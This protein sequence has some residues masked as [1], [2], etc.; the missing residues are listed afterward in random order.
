MTEP[1]ILAI[2]PGF[3]ALGLAVLDIAAKHVLS[4]SLI[5]TEREAKKRMVHAGSDDGRRIDM[6]S[7]EIAGLVALW[8]PAV[9]AYELPAAAKGSRAQHALGLAHGLVRATVRTVAT[10]LNQPTSIVE[11][12]AGD[13]K[14]ALGLKPRGVTK[15]DVERE[16]LWRFSESRPLERWA[17]ETKAKDKREHGFDACAV[18]VAASTTS[19]ALALRGRAA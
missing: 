12:T 8:Q 5:T 3:A 15:L 18:G 14:S 4:V 17:A 19:V 13:V 1:L 2:D 11:V 6:L 16:V 10:S 7:R 9:V